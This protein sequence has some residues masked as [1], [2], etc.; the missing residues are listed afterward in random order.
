MPSRT[1]CSVGG[2]QQ[3]MLAVRFV[4]M[5]RD[6]LKR[7]GVNISGTAGGGAV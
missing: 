7:L 2:S 4:E 1:C 6:T 5:R 3:V